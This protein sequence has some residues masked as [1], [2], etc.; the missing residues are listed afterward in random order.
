MNSF[1]LFIKDYRSEIIGIIQIFVA[2]YI[3]YKN[4]RRK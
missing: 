4:R 3:D 2:I 1:L